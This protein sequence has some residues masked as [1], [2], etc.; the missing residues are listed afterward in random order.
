MGGKKK[1]SKKQE[2]IAA[3]EAEQEIDWEDGAK[4]ISKKQLEKQK[5]QEEVALRK[6]ER[7]LQLE[8]EDVTNSSAKRK[9]MSKSKAN[10]KSG[11]HG[12]SD[13]DNALNQ[14]EGSENKNSGSINAEGLDDAIAALSLLKKDVVSDN[15][16][17][18]HP[19]RRF[20]A[21]LA[22]YTGRRMA[23]LRMENPGMRKHQLQSLAAKEFQKSDENPFNKETNVAY[24]ASEEEVQR[25]KDAIKQKRSKKIRALD[26]WICISQTRNLFMTFI[27]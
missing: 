18:R 27:M 11:N 13:L 14:I 9:G 25:L 5:K 24:N 10:K 23:D 16:I 17:E 1:K 22:E 3:P 19:E 15:D 20:K 8:I 7:E 2:E 12:G 4:K 6:R 21:A 26:N